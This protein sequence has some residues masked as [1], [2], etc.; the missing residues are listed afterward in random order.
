MSGLFITDCSIQIRI[1]SELK[2]EKFVI[3]KYVE[4]SK[5]AK[6]RFQLQFS[7]LKV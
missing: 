6:A 2:Y 4:K 3:L 1:F 7:C 5:Q